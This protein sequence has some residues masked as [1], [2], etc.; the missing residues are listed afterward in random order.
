M[1]QEHPFCSFF[2]LLLLQHC[3]VEIKKVLKL[4]F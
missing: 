1:P 3:Y 4:S 2:L